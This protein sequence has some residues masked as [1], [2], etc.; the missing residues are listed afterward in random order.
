MHMDDVRVPSCATS[1]EKSSSVIDANLV[2]RG[3]IV[4]GSSRSSGAADLCER[5]RIGGNS[6]GHRGRDL[7]PRYPERLMRAGEGV[8][9]VGSETAGLRFSTFFENPLVIA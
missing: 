9:H 1:V 7:R 4:D 8:V 5:P 2:A 6:L 3:S